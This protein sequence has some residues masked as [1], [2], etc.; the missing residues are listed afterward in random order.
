MQ[1]SSEIATQ[2][3]NEAVTRLPE[4]RVHAV[5]V[6][7]SSFYSSLLAEC[8]S[9]QLHF[10]LRFFCMFS[11]GLMPSQVLLGSARSVS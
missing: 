7:A 5:L 8:S 1:Q 9:L 6:S 2:F 3:S 4:R 10:D 11:V